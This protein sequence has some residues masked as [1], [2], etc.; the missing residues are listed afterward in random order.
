MK[1]GNIYHGTRLLITSSVKIGGLANRDEHVDT[2]GFL[3]S[4]V[5]AQE[6]YVRDVCQKLTYQVRIAWCPVS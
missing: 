2:G 1:G 3:R 4:C 5:L 6:S